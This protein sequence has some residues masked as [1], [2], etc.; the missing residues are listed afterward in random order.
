MGLASAW[1]EDNGVVLDES[2]QDRGVS[3]FSGKNRQRG[4]L[5][6][7]LDEVEAGAIPKNS[8]LLIE[9]LDRLSRENPWDS[10][11]VFEGLL[12]SGIVV[13]TLAD[14]KVYDLELMR[15]ESF[16]LIPVL[17]E[18]DRAH[19]ESDRKRQL[20]KS[21][22]KAK[23][24]A[25]EAGKFTKIKPPAWIKRDDEKGEF[26][27]IPER[28]KVVKRMFELADS[29]KGATAIAKLLNAEGHVTFTY[30]KPWAADNVDRILKMPAVVG[31]LYTKRMHVKDYFP[32][33]I[34]RAVFQRIKSRRKCGYNPTGK[35]GKHNIFVGIAVCGVCGMSMFLKSRVSRGRKYRYLQ[36][37]SVIKNDLCDARPYRYDKFEKHVLYHLREGA[38]ALLGVDNNATKEIENKISEMEGEVDACDGRVSLLLGV[39]SAVNSHVTTQEIKAVEERKKG[40]ESEVESLRDE[41]ALKT[42]VSS[43]DFEG[44]DRFYGNREELKHRMHHLLKNKLKRIEC[45]TNEFERKVGICFK[46]GRTMTI[47]FLD[48]EQ[49]ISVTGLG[50]DIGTRVAIGEGIVYRHKVHC[51]KGGIQ[52]YD[53]RKIYA[54]T[55]ITIQEI[56]NWGNSSGQF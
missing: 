40:L 8:Y 43:A 1:C 53:E 3:G 11:A 45:H 35:A 12:N 9:N 51:R 16:T 56:Q 13:V 6:R 22:W 39:L 27:L 42:E 5:R 17:V 31:E 44:V 28:A 14:N 29:G 33:V 34:E 4:A 15:K 38:L 18:L 37:S 47:K 49:N 54:D 32:P 48:D 41:L 52:C 10:R 30:G 24:T 20:S 21:A 26:W 46:N 2:Y 50:T 7:F 19:R 55:G 25:I 23:Q 36:C